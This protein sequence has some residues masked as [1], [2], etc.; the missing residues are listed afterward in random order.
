MERK[1]TKEELIMAYNEA[2]LKGYNVGQKDAQ[3]H[4]LALTIANTIHKNRE[5]FLQCLKNKS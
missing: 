5:E 2:Y 1:Y 3:S 4:P